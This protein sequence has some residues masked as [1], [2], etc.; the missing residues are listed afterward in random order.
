MSVLTGK[1]ALV[2]GASKGIGA[3]IAQGLAAA[4]AKL[5]VNYASS[6][7]GADKVVDE[8]VAKGG[9]AIAVQGD[10]SK[11]GEVSAL[12]GAAR[13][14]FGRVDILVNNAG[15]FAPTPLESLAEADYRRHFDIN[16]LGLLLASQAAAAQ[17]ENG[18]SIVNIGSLA[19]RIH[20]P[21][22]VVYNATKAAVDAITRTLAK[23][24][25]SRGIRVNSVNPGATDTEGTRAMFAGNEEAF[26]SMAA[27]APLG[28]VG[29]PADIARAVVFLA[30][31]EAG[32]ITGETLAAAGG[33]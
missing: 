19:S 6:R 16:V 27:T 18:G 29:L 11:P 26:T 15:V 22:L 30:S 3:G 31:D 13:E 20:P 1:V 2:T 24:L 10:V 8:I 4:G 5:V 7:E 33:M 28:R 25:G 23:D 21:G 9:E 17:F 12:F 32:W 14:R